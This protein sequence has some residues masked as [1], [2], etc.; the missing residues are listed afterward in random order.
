MIKSEILGASAGSGKTYRLTERTYESIRTENPLVIAVTFTRAATA[1]MRKR[2]LDWVDGSAAGYDDKLRQVMRAGGVYFST[3]D[4]FFY[5]L[6]AASG[7]PVELADEK[8]T[9]IIREKIVKSFFEEIQRADKIDEIIIACRLLGA[10][11]ETLAGEL[12]DVRAGRFADNDVS[13]DRFT[14]IVAQT[15]RLKEEIRLV[16]DALK[17]VDAEKVTPRVRQCVIGLGAADIQALTSRA[18]FAYSDL[19]DYSWLGGKIPWSSAPYSD[20]NRLFM[21]LREKLADYLRNRAILR[22]LTLT[23]MHGVYE[24]AAQKIKRKERRIFFEDILS[25]LIAL[26]GRDAGQRSEVMG[27]YFELGLDRV[28]H[29]MIDEFQDT[30][31]D[32]LELIFPLMEE[33]LSEVGENGEGERS[34]FIVGDWKQMI[35]AWRGADR[36]TIEKRLAPYRGGQLQLNFLRCNW[37][38][39]P[40]LIEL[41]NK[42]VAEIFPES[43]GD[44]QQLAPPDKVYGAISEINLCKV[45]MVQNQKAPFFE[46]MVETITAKRAEWGCDYSDMTLIFRTNT[47][48][49][50]MAQKLAEAGIGFSEVR[51]RQILASEE[52]VAIFSLLSYLFVEEGTDF[53]NRS[54]EASCYRRG[55][56][57]IGCRKERI[58]SRYAPPYGL[59]PLADVLGMCRGLLANPVI[60]AFREESEAFFRTGGKSVKDFLAYIFKVRD[61]VSVPEPAHSERVKLATIHGAKGLEFPHVFLLWMEQNMPFSF[62]V[63]DFKCH[64]SFTREETTF[65]RTCDCPDGS[66][67]VKARDTEKEKIENEKA[68]LLYV[69]M[70]RATQ[71]LTIFIK[72]GQDE[73]VNGK[74]AKKKNDCDNKKDELTKKL[75]SVIEKGAFD[76]EI[77]RDGDNTTW[78]K[79][80]G[81]RKEEDSA[82]SVEIDPVG[83]PDAEDLVGDVAELDRSYLA[84]DIRAGIERG[85]RIH[86]LLATL[87][88]SPE[89]SPGHGLSA[90]ELET[91]SSFLADQRVADILFRPGK[92]YTEQA[93]SNRE[94]YGVVDRMIIE[95]SRV[96]LID[97]KTGDP[98]D[99]LDSYL[100]QLRRYADIIKTLYPER[101]VE[102]YLLFVD[103]EEKVLAVELDQKPKVKYRVA[104]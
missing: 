13:S 20:I 46:R 68:N 14:R 101:A 98:G 84:R 3:F 63:P 100:E 15:A 77:T 39:T 40:L 12:S 4:S 26:D 9:E 53:M 6:L 38:S 7:E 52:G 35:Y 79:D 41:F 24:A 16:L 88:D 36:Q 49:E 61:K 44:E 33:I 89:L 60:E 83:F 104:R 25:R 59:Q 58:L 96:T 29:L 64:M 27:L 1:E 86:G 62:F 55:L 37:R 67:I 18:A 28:R 21:T 85:E 10:S 23:E 73:E 102:A 103:A 82:K 80:Y 22:E 32:N 11:I 2:I 42:T 97:Y 74:P 69:A 19:C 56:L 8:E 48:K 50:S 57:E 5:Q 78:R 51:G 54:L 66:K 91:V 70:T 47:D 45:E 30:S 92:L 87:G 75:V 81:P 34:L 65:W 99:L 43:D 95:K 76:A 71:S 17:R 31:R 72:K 94:R 90:A 93:I